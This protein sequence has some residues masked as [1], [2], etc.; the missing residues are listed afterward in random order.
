MAIARPV[1]SVDLI[2][3]AQVE[4][5]IAPGKYRFRETMQ[6]Q[7]RAF[8]G[9]ILDDHPAQRDIGAELNLVDFLCGGA[10]QGKGA[11]GSGD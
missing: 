11:C 4:G 3:A 9:R 8:S 6:K 1:E 10:G 2:V 5:E 7:N